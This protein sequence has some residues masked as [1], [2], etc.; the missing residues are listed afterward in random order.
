MQKEAISDSTAINSMLSK[1]FESDYGADASI[2]GKIIHMGF[3]INRT[4]NLASGVT[5]G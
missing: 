2:P 4:S 5:V 1:Q 3:R